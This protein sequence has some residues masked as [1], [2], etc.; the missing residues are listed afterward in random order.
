MYQQPAPLSQ[1]EGL[2]IQTNNLAQWEAVLKPEIYVQLKAEAERQNGLMNRH[3]SGYD[4]WR[5]QSLDSF[6]VNLSYKLV[7]PLPF[8]Y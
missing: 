7:P 4:V 8:R 5:G 6:I 1:A 2:A 3:T